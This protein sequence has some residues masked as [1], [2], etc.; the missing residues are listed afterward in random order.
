M[1][2]ILRSMDR[3]IDTAPRAVTAAL[4]PDLAGA[5]KTAS[6]PKATRWL[7]PL[8]RVAVGAAASSLC[9]ASLAFTCRAWAP[10]PPASASGFIAASR[11]PLYLGTQLFVTAEG[12]D[13]FFRTGDRRFHSVSID[14]AGRLRAAPQRLA[15]TN[16]GS[17]TARVGDGYVAGVLWR[18]GDDEGQRPRDL[19]ELLRLSAD[20]SVIERGITIPGGYSGTMLGLLLS[21]VSDGG[22]TV[23]YGR[24]GAY[25]DLF[26]QEMD[27]RARPRSELRR[28][29]PYAQS[30]LAWVGASAPQS[31]TLLVAA[32]D[33]PG[34][35]WLTLHPRATQTTAPE[36]VRAV[37]N[38]SD[39]DPHVLL[40]P[41]ADGFAMVWTSH[42]KG[43]VWFARCAADGTVRS[44]RK[45]IDQP[46]GHALDALLG[47]GSR[48]VLVINDEF[49]RRGGTLTLAL[50]GE[51]A[52]TGPLRSISEHPLVISNFV[53]ADGRWVAARVISDPPSSVPLVH[54]DDDGALVA[55]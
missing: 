35:P 3:S 43:Q 23:I 39:T 29:G 21:P 20:G 13:V 34:H 45:V 11:N 15:D 2:S 55:P 33:H 7:G 31:T 52:P 6:A 47:D 42:N 24:G 49:Q 54:L 4:A 32:G 40:A 19:I 9:V 44:S 50:D 26:A 53:R 37:Q 46:W 30:H 22:F 5:L 51:G 38:L 48:W 8:R 16:L 41:T 10:H 36:P 14:R 12:F 18:G 25:G 28:I 17:V 1:L 27:P